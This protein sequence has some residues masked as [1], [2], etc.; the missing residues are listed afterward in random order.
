MANVKKLIDDFKKSAL[1]SYL[2]STQQ[3]QQ[4]IEE[5]E[6]DI[7]NEV[8]EQASASAASASAASA[9][10]KTEDA[11]I[12]EILKLKEVITHLSAKI[13]RLESSQK[14]VSVI[15]DPRINNKALP[16]D[17]TITY[18]Y[19]AR[20]YKHDLYPGFIWR[21]GNWLKESPDMP[22]FK[23]LSPIYLKSCKNKLDPNLL[24]SIN[25]RFE[26]FIVDGVRLFITIRNV[27]EF[28][29]TSYKELPSNVIDRN[30]TLK[31]INNLF[32]QG[33]SVDMM[34][35]DPINKNIINNINLPK[36]IYPEDENGNDYI[37]GSILFTVY[38]YLPNY[39]RYR[40]PEYITEIKEYVQTLAKQIGSNADYYILDLYKYS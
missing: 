4:K 33:K 37:Q 8:A 14:V 20:A 26:P 10:S 30:A 31:K 21:N 40:Y 38:E 17:A 7:A 12:L 3:C 29:Y 34:V 19:G 32:K 6:Y 36:N 11:K 18:K 1:Y 28:C 16:N 35:Y 13:R 39:I 27:R 25:D 24:I 22:K 5:L 15:E 2:S 9:N 23:Q